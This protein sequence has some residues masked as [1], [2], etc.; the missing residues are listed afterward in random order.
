MRIVAGFHPTKYQK[1]IAQMTEIENNT[2]I[3]D[4]IF[5]LLRESMMV[6][7]REWQTW[8][9]DKLKVDVQDDFSIKS[10]NSMIYRSSEIV[11]TY[12][13]SKL[14]RVTVCQ[15]LDKTCCDK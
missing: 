15:E 5:E 7:Q 13:Y 9:N 10:S 1:Q 8:N 4:R 14:F 2:N 12:K 6:G 11:D 3:R